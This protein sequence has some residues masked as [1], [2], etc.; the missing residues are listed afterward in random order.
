MCT[1]HSVTYAVMSLPLPVLLRKPVLAGPGASKA[2]WW[3]RQTGCSCSQL[4]RAAS[5]ARM[6]RRRAWSTAITP[7]SMVA[8]PGLPE[9]VRS[10]RTG[11][12]R[13]M[14]AW[15]AADTNRTTSAFHLACGHCSSWSRGCSTGSWTCPPGCPSCSPSS[16]S[17]WAALG[18]HPVRR[19]PRDSDPDLPGR[20][21]GHPGRH[22]RGQPG[23]VPPRPGSPGPRRLPPRHPSRP[24]PESQP[25][26]SKR[27]RSPCC[28]P[29]RH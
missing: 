26:T 2:S 7:H 11:Q 14:T 12:R 24:D 17:S 22:H 29:R 16:G 10:A 18:P 23:Q 4:S 1:L 19:R 13:S 15:V 25:D 27:P 28:A 9:A 6:A 8:N 21:R 3:Q 20:D 5:M